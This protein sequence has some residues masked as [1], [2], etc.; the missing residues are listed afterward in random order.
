MPRDDGPAPR[1]L[2][3]SLEVGEKVGQN[4]NAHGRGAHVVVGDISSVQVE[5]KE[6]DHLEQ[7][8]ALVFDARLKPHHAPPVEKDPNVEKS[9]DRIFA[10]GGSLA[11]IS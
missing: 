2:H 6:Q 8:T 9:I 4:R 7:N 5:D 3:V 10:K 11:A 1:N